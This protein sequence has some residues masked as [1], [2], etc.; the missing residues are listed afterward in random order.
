MKQPASSAQM[1]RPRHERLSLS[2]VKRSTEVLE[3]PR[4]HSQ[5]P[6]AISQGRPL[7]RTISELRRAMIIESST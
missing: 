1:L 7:L 5:D 4:R 3:A 2:L 6:P